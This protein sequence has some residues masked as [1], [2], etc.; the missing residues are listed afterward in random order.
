VQGVGEGET[1]NPFTDDELE[2]LKDAV[3]QKETHP[4]CEYCLALKGL[5][6][7][8]KAAEK[9]ANNAYAS[10]EG[11]DQFKDIDL[12]FADWKRKAGK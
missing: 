7:R 12:L 1:M 5:F 3:K 4:L 6:A 11:G 9:L 8:L 10:L 2:A